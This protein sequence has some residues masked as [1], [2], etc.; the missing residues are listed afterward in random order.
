MQ[1]SPHFS[2]EEL[3]FTSHHGLDNTPNSDQLSNLEDLAAGHLEACRLIVGPMHVNSGFR[4]P[5]VNAAVGGAS[6][7][8][9]MD[10]NAC[11]WTALNCTVKQA[12]ELILNSGIQF[13]QLIYEWGTWVHISR[14]PA[15]RAPRHQALMIG[16][17]TG[18]K[19]LP[20]DSSAIPS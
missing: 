10:G 19:Y 15:G 16:S 5:G 6:T 12:Y 9:H 7:S 2:Y 17:W 11:D 1:L 14:A 3:T 13:D 20:Y 8:Q 18:G 4:S